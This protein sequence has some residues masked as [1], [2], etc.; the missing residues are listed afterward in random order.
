MSCGN[1]HET[2][3]SQVIEQMFAY[4]DGELGD[5]DVHLISVHLAEC[6]PCLSEHDVDAMVKKLVHRAGGG[7]HAPG[8]LRERILVSI[9]EVRSVRLQTG[10]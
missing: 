7:E 3:C 1:H 5:P 6:G 4:I 10:G 9:T 8:T 2:P